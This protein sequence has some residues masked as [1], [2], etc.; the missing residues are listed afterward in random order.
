LRA[1]AGNGLAALL[2]AG[3]A[4]AADVPGRESPDGSGPRAEGSVDAR[5]ALDEQAAPP[6]YGKLSGSLEGTFG[7]RWLF[8]I[9]IEM[10][11]LRAAIGPGDTFSRA[12]MPYGFASVMLGETQAGLSV[13][14]VVI[15]GRVDG[16]LSYFH[17]GLSF[18][19]GQFWLV[20]A[21]DSER[22]K[23]L[24]ALGELF[25]GPQVPLGSHLALSVDGSFAAELLP[26]HDGTI[27][28]GPGLTLRLR[29]Y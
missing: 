8:G 17:G 10:K 4:Q 14:H 15:G 22:L 9:P 3:A 13:G 21:T 20:R 1:L 16:R 11:E 25:V 12:V 7:K 24:A 28:Y 18:G 27:V 29:I 5:T 6:R 2:W 26:G 19:L 23:N